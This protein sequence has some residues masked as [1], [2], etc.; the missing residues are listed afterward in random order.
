M[1]LLNIM[2]AEVKRVFFQDSETTIKLFSNLLSDAI[3]CFLAV[4]ESLTLYICA[5]D[6][7]PFDSTT[8]LDVSQSLFYLRG[9]LF[10]LED[11]ADGLPLLQRL[12]EI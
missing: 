9:E 10:I 7:A 3:I 2:L 6:L 1:K 8:C 5:L 4:S 12:H 11:L